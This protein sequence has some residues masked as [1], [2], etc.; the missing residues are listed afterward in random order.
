MR[1]LFS[2][3]YSGAVFARANDGSDVMMDTVV[4]NITGLIDMLE[5]R[6]GL[7]YEETPQNERLAHYYEAVCRYMEDEPDNIMAA[8]FRTSGLATAKAML[9]WRDE[10]C[11]AMWIFD[12]K[13]ISGRLKAL[14]CVE[15]Y[16]RKVIRFDLPGRLHIVGD[17]IQAQSL[18]CSEMVFHMAVPQELLKPA[19][20]ELFDI[21]QEH[22]AKV[23][24]AEQA[25]DNGTN[26][27]KIRNLICSNENSR[28]KLDP[29]DESILIYRFSDE[30]EACEYLSFSDMED[31]DVWIN[32]SN[33]QMD[34]WLRLMNKSQSGSAVADCSPQL[35]QLFVMGLSLFS[36]PL[37]VYTLIEWLNMPLHPISRYFRSVLADEIV[38]E[39]GYRNAKCKGL[40]ERY[41]NGDYVY[42]TPEE[43]EMTPQKQAMIRK[44]D[45]KKRRKLADIFLPSIDKT[46]NISAASVRT[47]VRELSSWSRQ[48]AALLMEEEGNAQ[49]VEQ[50]SAVAGM[51]DAFHILLSTV[52][53][54][55][56]EY[57]T[58]DSWMS[59]IYQKN[60]YTST[61]AEA[62]C[63]I[64]VDSPSK[65]A[66]SAD[67][68]VWIGVDG[69]AGHTQECAFLYPSE[70]AGLTERFSYIRPWGDK[71]QN[72]YYERM[73]QTP[74]M[75]TKKQ[76]IL[77]VR[78]R[79]AD[80]PSLKHPLMVRL[81]QQIENIDAITRYPQIG[82]KSRRKVN[83]FDNAGISAELEFD[84]ADKLRW[85]DHLS[86]TS[87]GTLVEHPFDY[88]M[89]NL[90]D[91]TADGKAKM[92]NVKT[93][94]GNVAHAV[95]DALFSPRD[96]QKY[97]TWEQIDVRLNSEYEKVYSDIIEANG[98]ILLLA[99]NKL[100][101]K[102]LHEQLRKCLDALLE[103]LRDNELKVTGCE[104]YVHGEMDLGLPKAKDAEGNVKDRDILGYIDMTLEDK[105]GH[106]VVFDFKWTTWIKGYQE[107]LT[108]NRSIQL[109]LYR[110]MLGRSLGN[111][112][113]RVAYFLMPS[114]QLY[115]RE[116]FEGRFCNQLH[117]ENFDD[118]VAQ[119]R[120]SAI[121]RKNQIEGGIV[122][123]NGIF[124]E[125][126]Y[127]KDTKARG[128]Y[129]L[130]EDE[131]LGIK[132]EN[133]FSN[134]KLFKS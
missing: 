130:K 81:E 87:I 41:I 84:F 100:E 14:V 106:P 40:I 55:V 24:P 120:E 133:R 92:D 134:Y 75:M 34:N 110:W 47:F 70:R 62:G 119:L 97:S 44:R 25:E 46:G 19:V 43:K 98:A 79:V 52:K 122:E 91:I 124:T 6:L 49:W 128:L 116:H 45:M 61:I 51:C 94:M 33:K 80:E 107:I 74:L 42:L 28:I 12:G 18:D 76:L 5:L 29:K 66:S 108:K 125:L 104:Y 48:R 27:S 126:Q 58:I 38:N 67:K 85:S 88:L 59:T 82:K 13:E 109:E 115:S 123:T 60:T 39:G 118:I 83:G 86:P 99:E 103:I 69:D 7:H 3:E 111:E 65:I 21:L 77:V 101:E 78:D 127:V 121:Y 10:L 54:P 4:L 57:R 96:D 11:S 132:T 8:S 50:L 56:L 30:K 22:G 102:L 89:E 37:N 63:R 32:G 129:P 71:E 31:V 95:I 23:V 15:D 1:I 117:S 73:M 16:F 90:L 20:R 72:E 35:T 9:G 64:V 36:K 53:D 112:V 114:G 105:D 26:L 68:T 131:E 93:T 113:E 2:P 17:Q